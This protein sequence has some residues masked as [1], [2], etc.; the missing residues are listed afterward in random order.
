MSEATI[1]SLK[2]EVNSSA[3]GASQGLDALTKSLNKLQRATGKGLGLTAVVQELQTA[4]KGINSSLDG[5]NKAVDMLTKL[6]SV[7]ISASIGNQIK[8]ISDALKSA[9]FTGSSAKMQELATA[10][11]PL[12]QMGKS[13]LSSYVTQLRK[14]PDV[15]KELN[16]LDMSAVFA[17]MQELAT[18]IKPLGN[19]MQKIASGFS[20][21][22]AKLQKLVANTDRLTTSNN[23]ASTSYINLYAKI[24]MAYYAVSRISRV[25]SGWITLSNDYIETMNLFTVSMGKYAESAYNYAQ[26][27]SDTMGI[28]PKDWLQT[29]GVFM[30]LVKGFGVVGDRANVMSQQLT[31]L[32]YDISSFF[33]ISVED[34]MTKLQ[35]GISGEL[36]PLRR[37]GYDLSQA[38]LEAVALSLGIDKAVSSMT[39]AEKAELRY[40]AIMTQVTDAHGDMARTLNAP[41]NQLRILGAQVTQLGRSLGNIFI[42]IVNN[43]L[44]TAIAIVRVLREAVAEL[45]SVFGIELAD[46]DFGTSNVVSDLQDAQDEVKKLKSYTMGIDELNII[47]ADVESDVD[48]LGSGFDYDLPTYDFLGD[49]VSTKIEEIMEKL[50]PSVEWLRDNFDVIAGYV[51]AVGTG[52]LAWKFEKGFTNMVDAIRT[53]GLNKVRMGLT[54]EVIGITLAY[55][56]SYNIGYD[57]PSLANILQTAI[58]DA[59]AVGGSLLIFG[60]GPLGWTIGLGIALVTTITGI[61]I[62]ANDKAIAEDMKKRFGEIILSNE[63]ITT[64]VTAV[65]N[66]DWY[67]NVQLYL[68]V[69]ADLDDLRTQLESKVSALNRYGWKVR[70]GIELS[71]SEMMGYEEAITEYIDAANKYISDRGYAISLGVTATLNEGDVVNSILASN[72]AITKL[73]SDD[74]AGLGSELQSYLN[75][76]FSDGVLTIDEQKVIDS[77]TNQINNVLAIVSQSEFEAKLDFIDL[78]YGTSELSQE[79]WEAYMAEL[80]ATADQMKVAAEETVTNTL[81]NLRANINIAEYYLAQDPNNEEWKTALEDAR[82][83]YQLYMDSN[84]MELECNNIDFIVN[85]QI[86][87][88]FA[89]M[90]DEE[91]AKAKPLMGLTVEDAFNESFMFGVKDPDDIFDQ[92]LESLMNN[93]QNYWVYKFKGLDI[94]TVT[95]KNLMSKIEDCVPKLK[96]L[97]KALN[98]AWDAGDAISQEIKD[99]LTNI[100][101]FQAMSDD[102]TE[103]MEGITYLMGYELSQ[104]PG[105]YEML[106]KADNLGW[107]LNE[108]LALGIKSSLSFVEDASGEIIKVFKDGVEV[109]TLDVTPDLVEN[110]KNLGVNLSEGLYEGLDAKMEEDKPWYKK[111]WSAICDWFKDLFGIHSPSTVFKE[112]GGYLSEGLFIGIGDGLGDIGKWVKTNVVEP[113]NRAMDGALTFAVNVKNNSVEWWNN[114]KSWWSSKV[115]SVADFTTNVSNNASTWWTNVKTWWSNVVGEGKNFTTSVT[116]NA[117]TWWTNVKTWWSGVVGSVSGFSTTVLNHSSTWWENVKAWWG[118]KVG[119]VGEFVTNVKDT[120][121]TWWTNVK[122]WWNSDSKTGVDLKVNAVKGW[123]STL[124]AALGIPDSFSLGFHLP[125]IRVTWGEKEVLGFKISYPNG[126]ETYAQGGFPDVGQ[127]FVAREAGPELVGTIGNKNAVVNND[128]IVESVS[129]GVYQAVLAALGGNNEDEG[130][131]NIVINLDG[132]KIY[133]NQQKIARGRGYNLGMG[134]FSFG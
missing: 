52:L 104:S 17:K 65:L 86:Y 13:N 129:A 40:Y 82:K 63:E 75:E 98:D 31:Q 3:S 32:G 42:P 77:L 1:D 97:K 131:T 38:K 101:T 35:S 71:E 76:A 48:N 8:S 11:A 130:N 80:Q 37:I 68:S 132:E 79:S 133:E 67:S 120:S 45:M 100:Y 121:Y 124:K 99:G 19:E 9:D 90:F 18:A 69:Q 56:G 60:T 119:S 22:P 110:M 125:R 109:A 134:A 81:S 7:K 36:E 73:L 53:G 87:N 70:L 128:Q 57:G 94:S 2:L 14:L 49:V 61:T 115:G 62:G 117:N 106:T 108:E 58:G 84:P 46:V 23:R 83:A 10:L 72:S 64:L 95:K 112:Y 26:K 43:M 44:P 34:A 103:Q 55:S 123:T 24:R 111:T 28:D 41:A 105:F 33:N 6:G 93:F 5:L 107:F 27:V 113:F 92:P 78:K 25:V 66:N 122:T 16:K 50:R 89:A 102:I 126:F 59:L 4:N 39:Q 116:N 20:A 47:N 29:Q 74:M 91:L 96:D 88:H 127:M 51:T 21:F 114:V 85:D 30:T 12:Q 118:S 15:M 54:I